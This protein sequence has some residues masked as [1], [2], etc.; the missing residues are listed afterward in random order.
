MKI[1]NLASLALIATLLW[2]CGGSN[3]EAVETTEAQEVPAYLSATQAYV[4]VAGSTVNW[5]GFKTYSGDFHIGTINIQE[6]VFQLQDGKLVGGRFVI[7]M[8][9]I[10]CKDLE[11]SVYNAKLVN[12][13]KS[14][15]FFAV[16]SFPTAV[17]EITN[18]AEEAN[19]EKGTTH[20]IS[21]NLTIRGITKNITFPATV[22]VNENGVSLSAPEFGV[23]RTQ[24]N[25]MFRSSG[26][27]GVLKDQLI[28]DNFLL[29]LDVKG[30]I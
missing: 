23:N 5:K 17:F 10:V 12:H 4:D 18:V 6:G 28:D 21:G 25:V 11:D 2:S 1:H 24:F 7:D 20:L 3:T 29:T 16:D 8:N 26:I 15:D 13:L 30:N 22:T 27:K 14:N 19:A 9:S